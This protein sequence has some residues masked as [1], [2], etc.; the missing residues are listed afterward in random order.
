MEERSL[1]TKPLYRVIMRKRQYYKNI[2]LSKGEKRICQFFDIYNIPYVREK[3]F[4]DCVN[5]SGNH[6]RY[7]FYLE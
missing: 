2:R 1:I 7:D 4:K 5:V 6:L 3:I